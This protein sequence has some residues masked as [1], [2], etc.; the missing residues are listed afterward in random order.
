MRRV[1]PA[2]IALLLAGC[3]L[4]SSPADG[5]TFTAPSGWQPS[6]GILGFMQFWKPPS[7][8]D[9]ILMLFKSP[10]Q[11]D[12]K[13]AFSNAKLNDS[14]IDEQRDIKICGNQDAVYVKGE[15]K[16]SVNSAPSRESDMQMVMS[17]VSGTSYFA[18]YIYPVHARPNAEAVSALRELCA[19]R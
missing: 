10:K 18:M 7:G 15:A 16:S 4:T 12:T 17:N 8:N 6:P 1:I 13:E 11:I 5:L 19:K 9:E 14:H 3:G 2:L